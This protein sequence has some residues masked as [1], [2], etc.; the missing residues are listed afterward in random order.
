M[1]NKL[2]PKDFDMY[3]S[4]INGCFVRLSEINDMIACG[5]LSIDVDKLK[6]YQFDSRVEY[7]G[8]L[9]REEAMNL[10]E[11]LLR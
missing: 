9:S 3:E 8:S 5:A 2:Y 6:E 4:N 1:Q 7:R 10:Y 11:E